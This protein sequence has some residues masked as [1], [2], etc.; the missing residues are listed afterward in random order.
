MLINKEN[1]AAIFVAFNVLFQQ[2]FAAYTPTY[3]QVAMD[4]PSTTSQEDYGWLGNFPEMREWL[5]DRQLKNLKAHKYSIVNK[6]WESSVGM[7]RNDIDDDKIGLF[8][9]IFSE[10]AARQR[11]IRTSWYT[12]CWPT[13]HQTVL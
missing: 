3:K 8:K 5:G 11:R 6:D 13:V 12:D 10:M 9:P 4:V 7:D 1:L 2:A